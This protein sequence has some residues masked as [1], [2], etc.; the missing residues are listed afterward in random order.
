M[1]YDL[2]IAIRCH[3][4]PE[5]VLD[6]IDTVVSF[7]NPRYTKL[8]IAIDN[9]NRKLGELLNRAVPN[10]VFVS[11]NTWGWGAGLYGLLSETVCW[12]ASRWKFQHFMSI[13]YDTL[14]IGS[15]VDVAALEQITEPEFGLIGHYD[16]HNQH[17]ATIYE[18][19]KV[20]LREKL[21][22]I[23]QTYR[24]GEGVQGGCFVMTRSLLDVMASRGMFRAPFAVAKCFTQ[25]ADDHLIPLFC[26]MCNLEIVP[27]SKKFYIR[28]QLDDRPFDFIKRG[29]VAF[30]PT[31]IRPDRK[32]FRAVEINV[33]N[34]FRRLR[35]RELLR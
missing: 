24:P 21:G 8:V 3:A 7:T 1:S 13:D 27:Y 15:G 29:I 2:L 30:H 32:D 10:S 26:R 19:D 23:P 4:Y 6:T 33:R 35:G 18:R 14:F 12:A 28:W 34:H 31:K 25:I 11:P 9:N 22:K 16:S 17:W 5:F 20:K